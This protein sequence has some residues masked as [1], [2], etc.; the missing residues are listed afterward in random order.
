MSH[1]VF[2]RSGYP[3]SSFC[4]G[5]TNGFCEA[6]VSTIWSDDA[7]MTVTGATQRHPFWDFQV[8][9]RYPS[10][11]CSRAFVD[12]TDSQACW[13]LYLFV[14][15]HHLSMLLLS[16]HCLAW[17]FLMFRCSSSIL[18]ADCPSHLSMLSMAWDLT[19]LRWTHK[20]PLRLGWS[21]R[22][23][24]TLLPWLPSHT[25]APFH[26]SKNTPALSLLPR[27]EVPLQCLKVKHQRSQ[28]LNFSSWP[29]RL[30]C[31]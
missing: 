4:N 5:V 3:A 26:L 14:C 30:K 10:C 24:P 6:S 1:T 8:T 19:A 13:K 21:V 9:Q 18:G 16:G 27:L 29:S 25:P 12:E 2:G 15:F 17:F 23:D 22:T 7:R 28:Q 20:V 31:R 11:W